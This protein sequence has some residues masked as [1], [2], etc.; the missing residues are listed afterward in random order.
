MRFLAFAILALV[1]FQS[2]SSSADPQALQRMV[3]SER[4]FAA[5]TAEIGFRD[6]FL[7]FFADDSIKIQRQGKN[8]TLIPAREDLAAQPLPKLPIVNQLIWEPFTGHI[9][10]DG[11]LGWLT[12]PFVLLNQAQKT[13]VGQGAYFSVWKR[14]ANGTYRVWLDEGI[15]LPSIWLKAS[16]FRVAPEPDEGAAGTANE[17]IADAERAV[18]TDAGAWRARLAADARVHRDAAGRSR[19]SCRVGGPPE[20][21]AMRPAPH[22]DGGL[23]RSRRGHRCLRAGRRHARV[24]RARVETQ[25]RRPLAHRV[26]DGGRQ[27]AATCRS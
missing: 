16:P 22:G 23:R 1:S 5:A 10:S 8:V 6:G 18:S 11:T 7:A 12:G 2:T 19:R 3:A 14:Q 4:A 27:V 24:V 26:S 17:A 25:P 20:A 15:R 9:S 21:S 13:T